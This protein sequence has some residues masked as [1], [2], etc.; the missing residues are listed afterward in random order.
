MHVSGANHTANQVCTTVGTEQ[1]HS[2]RSLSRTVTTNRGNVAAGGVKVCSEITFYDEHYVIYPPSLVASEYPNFDTHE[3]WFTVSHQYIFKRNSSIEYVSNNQLHYATTLN[4][5]YSAGAQSY[6]SNNTSAHR[7]I[8]KTKSFNYGDATE[9]LSQ[10]TLVSHFST[11]H[12]VTQAALLNANDPAD[13]VVDVYPSGG[14]YSV[15]GYFQEYGQG[16]NRL[17]EIGSS[18]VGYILLT[19][20]KKV[21]PRAFIGHHAA[22]QLTTSYMYRDLGNGSTRS[23]SATTVYFVARGN[24]WYMFI[25]YHTSVTNQKIEIP[26]F[27]AGKSFEVLEKHDNVTVNTT[28]NLTVSDGVNL[29]V[30]NNYGYLVLKI[31]EPSFP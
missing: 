20:I 16:A 25:D 1:N 12:I 5:Y 3:R 29:T 27:F 2:N 24:Q 17:A 4:D 9:D 7:F 18:A 30:A 15:V 14:L 23:D 11:N 22:G 6:L 13:R 10:K 26:G 31:T 19:G 21:Y 28:G 8:P